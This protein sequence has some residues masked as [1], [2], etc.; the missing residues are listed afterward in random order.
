MEWREDGM[1]PA[2]T[3]RDGTKTSPVY[4]YLRRP[5]CPACG[6]TRLVT[7]RSVDNGDDSRTR[8]ATCKA[9]DCGQRVV[10]VC[11]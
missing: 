6:S 8:Y 9:K 10:I 5:R 3:D 7:Y 11:E 2:E 4:L 1:K